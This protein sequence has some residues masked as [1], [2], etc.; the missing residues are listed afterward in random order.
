MVSAGAAPDVAVLIETDE[1]LDRIGRRA[2][3]ASDLG[4]PVLASLAVLAADVDLDPAPVERTRRAAL[5]RAL[6]PP[7]RQWH[8]T[9]TAGSGCCRRSDSCH[10][11]D[12]D[13]L[14]TLRGR[15]PRGPGRAARRRATDACGRRFAPCRSNPG[16]DPAGDDRQGGTRVGRRRRRPGALDD[17][18]RSHHPRGVGQSCRCLGACRARAVRRGTRARAVPI[19]VGR[20]RGPGRPRPTTTGGARRRPIPPRCPAEPLRPVPPGSVPSGPCRSRRS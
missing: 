2:H 8:A 20:G 15:R 6:W 12:H 3:A 7:D 11:A 5:E 13:A 9:G 1:L 14:P 17:G 16:H 18:G 19:V 10:P 4:D